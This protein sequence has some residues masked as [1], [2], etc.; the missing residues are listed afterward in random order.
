MRRFVI[1]IALLLAGLAAAAH[2]VPIEQRNVAEHLRLFPEADA[3]SH[4]MRPAVLAGVFLVPAL[5]GLCYNFGGRLTRYLVRQFLG[6]FAVCFGG[7]TTIWLLIDL[8]DNLT[9]L[10]TSGDFLGTALQ[11][12]TAR[13]A[14]LIITLLPY[15][16]L[17]SLLFALGRLSASREIIA[18]IQTGRGLAR[19]TW[20]FV[21]CGL[22]AT[23]LAAGL[24]FHWAPQARAK[25][26]AILRSAMGLDEVAAEIVQ[27]RNP[28][29]RRLWMVGAFP[30]DFQK[31][32]PLERVRIVEENSDGT[33]ARILVARRASWTP[34]TG[35]WTFESPTLRHLRPDQPPRF[36]RDLPDPY[37]VKTWR[38]TP[39]E[40]I[41]PGLPAEQLGIPE[42]TGWLKNQSSTRPGSGARHLTQWHHRIA[43]PFN[44]LI[45]VLLATP[46]GIV[47]SRR[48]ASGGVALAVLLAGGLMFLTNAC[49]SLGDAGHL[50][51][52]VAAWFPN[53]AFGVLALYLFRRRL[54]GRPIY[55]VIR[56]LLPNES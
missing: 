43:Q 26:R 54:A 19:L 38:E 20:P 14:E 40:I 45:V 23:L 46:L 10:K 24:N 22:L 6:V 28:R 29:V 36:Q 5:A 18:V 31:G 21:I 11:L 51:P 3:W 1:S 33:L 41:Q 32:A 17:L 9:E 34:E 55:Q 35:A 52:V 15:A 49:L 39:A 7:L 44:C 47:F 56:G 4:Q 37:V 25:E 53:L 12:Y 27:F 30:P 2:F 48:G 16:L 42:L 13:I 50:P 8:D